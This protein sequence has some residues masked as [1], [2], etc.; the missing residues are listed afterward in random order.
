MAR[1]V[2][3][4]MTDDLDGETPADESVSFALDG[5]AYEIDLTADNARELREGLARFVAAARTVGKAAGKGKAAGS[6]RTGPAPAEVRAWA[7]ENGHEVPDRG[8]IPAELVDAY[9][10]AQAAA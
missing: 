6:K 8:R 1:K 9:R 10:E 2:H 3:V 4:Y 7:R 5:T